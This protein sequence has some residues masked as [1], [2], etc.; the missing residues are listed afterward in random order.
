MFTCAI[1]A[2]AT[3][4]HAPALDDSLA[5]LS[6]S[7]ADR[8]CVSVSPRVTPEAAAGLCVVSGGGVRGRLG[9]QLPTELSQD[10][11]WDKEPSAPPPAPSQGSKPASA[12]FIQLII[13]FWF[14]FY[15]VHIS[16]KAFFF[17][18]NFFVS[19]PSSKSSW[20]HSS[21]SLSSS[22]S[23]DCRAICAV[24]TTSHTLNAQR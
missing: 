4:T 11:Q 6:S 23:R 9:E 19:Q 10:G 7:T 5:F 3:P 15:S 20:C 14:V 1:Y 21:S 12:F 13:F 24:H 18:V 22:V 2:D 8:S 17:N 16:T